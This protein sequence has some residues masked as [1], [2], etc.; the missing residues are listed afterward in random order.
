M[1]FHV[2]KYKNYFNLKLCLK[3][4]CYKELEVTKDRQHNIEV[5]LQV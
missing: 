1:N 3:A 5:M 2:K 4:L